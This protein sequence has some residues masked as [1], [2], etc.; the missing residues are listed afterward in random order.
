MSRKT[1]GQSNPHKWL[2]SWKIWSVEKLETLPDRW[3][4]SRAD[5]RCTQCCT[6]HDGLSI[7]GTGKVDA[8]DVAL[9]SL[10]V[11]LNLAKVI[12]STK[13]NSTSPSNSP[14]LRFGV[15]SNL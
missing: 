12:L 11:G 4:E 8:K 7:Q 6:H 5:S 9:L 15:F 2:A 3:T 1:G 14:Y 13:E 10:L